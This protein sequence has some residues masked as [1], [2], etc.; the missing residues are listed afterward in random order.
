[1]R[2]VKNGKTGETLDN[3]PRVLTCRCGTE[4]ECVLG[5]MKLQLDSNSGNYYEIDCPVCDRPITEAA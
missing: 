4:I 1:M 3:T 2:V 5:E